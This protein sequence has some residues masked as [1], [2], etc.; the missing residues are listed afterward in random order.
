MSIAKLP[1]GDW[2]EGLSQAYAM[3]ETEALTIDTA[4]S[5]MAEAKS[6]AYIH[7]DIDLRH[8]TEIGAKFARRAVE[9]GPDV[10]LYADL[11]V[12]CECGRAMRLRL[13]PGDATKG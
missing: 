9:E 10:L 6:Y 5:F 1:K 12:R 4:G 3:N 11:H 13:G 2:E 8:L 7:G